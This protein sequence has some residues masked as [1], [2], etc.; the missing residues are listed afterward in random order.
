M[1]ESKMTRPWVLA[2]VLLVGGGDAVADE[3]VQEG[4]LSGPAGEPVTHEIVLS[5]FDSALGTLNF[6]RLDFLTSVIGGGETDGSGIAVH[7]LARLTADYAF[8]GEVIAETEA[9]V[10]TVIPN[11]GPPIAFTVF[12]TDTAT[13]L[14]DRAGTLGKWIGHDDVLMTAVVQLTVTEDPAGILGFGAGGTV[15]Y[16]VT[17]DYE[18]APACVADLDGSGDVGFPD[19]LTLL[20]EWGCVGTCLADLDGSGDVGFADLV[21]LLASWG[22]CR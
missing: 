19:L 4:S 8:L 22:A 3:I 12:G 1:L 9:L 13:V 7:I 11:T 17:Y 16:T 10:D 14:Y 2:L 20:A 15:R 18:P 6:V 5:P 21:L